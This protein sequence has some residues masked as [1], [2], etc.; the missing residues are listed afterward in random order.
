[1][2]PE[3]EKKCRKTQKSSFFI[4]QNLSFLLLIDMGLL[5]SSD[6][7]WVVVKKEARKE[8]GEAAGFSG[9]KT[10]IVRLRTH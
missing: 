2:T 9:G 3:F 5:L 10:R 8:S 6:F 7:G 1:M 4:E